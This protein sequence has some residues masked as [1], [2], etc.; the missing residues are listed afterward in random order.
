MI[1][2][3]IFL[4]LF[5]ALIQFN[6]GF[7]LLGG[8]SIACMIFSCFG[9][10][11]SDSRKSSFVAGVFAFGISSV[12]SSVYLWVMQ[13]DI[14]LVSDAFVYNEIA[15]QIAE[16]VNLLHQINPFSFQYIFDIG[17]GYGGVIYPGFYKI[18]GIIY[19]IFDFFAINNRS[20]QAILLVNIFSYS[21]I[22]YIF[23]SL[24]NMNSGSKN[25]NWILWCI[26]LFTPYLLELTIWL[27][28][29]IFLLMISLFFVSRV[30]KNSNIFIIII[31][32][33]L[34][35]T[36]R[37]P[38]ALAL[39]IFYIFFLTLSSNL[40]F[41]DIFRFNKK[42]LIALSV[43]ACLITVPFAPDIET[44]AEGFDALFLDLQYN[45]GLS[46][47]FLQNELGVA[48][49]SLLYPLPNIAP[50]NVYDFWRSIFST[51]QILMTFFVLFK[52]KNS[53]IFDNGKKSLFLLGIIFAAINALACILSW[54]EFGFVVFEPRHKIFSVSIF[55]L[56]F[57]FA[58]SSNLSSSKNYA[59]GI[60]NDIRNPVF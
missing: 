36:L 3:S 9:F 28:K 11:V 8:F 18:M 5:G 35:S 51:A 32:L 20:I 33:F 58:R 21:A 53:Q 54:R 24:L 6:Y 14:G 40:S 17:D 1:F 19:T 10:F 23:H 27:R 42:S 25:K 13:E 47:I 16:Q 7:T 2:F 30:L 50:K 45:V 12:Y 39:L 48:V 15:E 26:L 57:S 29:D 55:I 52:M 56:I 38:Q 60:K 34:I 43:V 46:S 37:L 22:G 44:S 31:T 49:Y 4:V 59:V 41:F